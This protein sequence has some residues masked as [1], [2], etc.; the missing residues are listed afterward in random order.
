MHRKVIL[1]IAMSV[2]GHIAQPQDD[3][4]F[5]SMVEQDGEDYGYEAF[6]QSVDTVIMGRRT[7]DKVLSMGVPHPHA[8]KALYVVTRTPRPASGNVTFHTG[9]VPALIRQL[10]AMPGQHIYCDGGAQLANELLRHDLIDELVL[11]VI[12]VLTGSGLSLFSDGRPE[13]RLRLISAKAF[14]KGLVQL[15]YSR[16]DR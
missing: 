5:L 15:H 10:Q 2:D 7:Y 16:A 8:D 12:P 11:S 1:Y 4:G 13:Q 9:D 14:P 6:V 3:L